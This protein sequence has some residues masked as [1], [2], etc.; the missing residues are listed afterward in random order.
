MTIH[1]IHPIQA[2]HSIQSI[3]TLL[4]QYSQYKAIQTIQAVLWA[5]FVG[6][7][8]AYLSFEGESCIGC[9][10]PYIE[11]ERKRIREIPPLAIPP[12]G[13]DVRGGKYK[14]CTQA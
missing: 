14:G 6:T 12:C 2:I 13:S 8:R 10:A 9:I 7:A 4:Q 1:S 3:Q 5:F 11:I